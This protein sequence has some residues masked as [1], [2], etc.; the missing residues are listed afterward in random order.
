MNDKKRNNPNPDGYVTEKLCAAYRETLHVEIK[1]LKD[2]IKTVGNRLWY[3]LGS[4]VVLGLIAI[5]TAV[6]H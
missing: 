5:L 4:V 3:V 1:G 6:F 2:D